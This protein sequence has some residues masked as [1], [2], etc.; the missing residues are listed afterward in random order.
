MSKP[1]S[2][3]P[4]TRPPS[5][6]GRAPDD[7]TTNDA[8]VVGFLDAPLP[9]FDASSLPTCAS[10]LAL[11]CDDLLV[12]CEQS[13]GCYSPYQCTLG[14]GSATTCVC[15]APATVVSPFF[16]LLRCV[17]TFACPAAPCAELCTASGGDDGG[18]LLPLACEAEGAFQCPV[19]GMASGR[20]RSSTAACEAC[21]ASTC[22]EIGAACTGESDCQAYLVCLATCQ[23]PTCIEDCTAAHPSGQGAADALD[24]CVGASCGAACGY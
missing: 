2:V 17:S 19:D 10:C 13:S 21:V 5:S 24:V 7:G 1:C 20:A 14:G 16:A 23:G 11:A 3:A 6:D 12:Q 4:S 15:D 9:H 18:L 8:V 22:P